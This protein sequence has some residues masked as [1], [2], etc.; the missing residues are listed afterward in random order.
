MP[1]AALGARVP[2]PRVLLDELTVDDGGA[3]APVE[4]GGTA[5]LTLDPALQ[6]AAT[7]LL[8]AARPASGAI[9]AIDPRR[10]EI[11][12]WAGVRGTAP[13]PSVVASTL[14]PAASL[15]KIVT[16]T[17]LLEKYVDPDRTVCIEGGS[18]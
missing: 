3:T 8:A 15:F 7:R 17:A 18:S 10:G 16:T 4:G 13:A 12:A 6:R 5:A 14:A 1:R 9:V 11:L 2:A